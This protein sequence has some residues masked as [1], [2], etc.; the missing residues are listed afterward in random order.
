MLESSGRPTTG[1]I[2]R[3]TDPDRTAKGEPRASVT[4]TGLRTLWF[5]TGSLCN[6]AC[7]NC[8][9]ESSPTSDRLAYLSA[10]DVGH[11]LDEVKRARLPV[12]EVGFTGG[13]PFMNR[14]LPAMLA[15]ALGRGFRALVLTNAMK[16]M[17]HRRR[18]LLALHARHG[19]ALTLRVSIDH[20]QPAKHEKVRGAGTWVPM[21]EGLRWLAGHGFR[22]DAAGRKLWDETEADLRAGFAA[23]FR[24]EGIGIDADDPASLVL[25]PEMDLAR[26]APE[27]TTRC[28]DIVGKSP[29][30][31]MCASSRMVIRRKGA[32]SPVVVPCTLL[33]YDPK[34]E[35][36]PSVATAPSTVKLNHPFCA[37]FCVLGG[38]S[39]SAR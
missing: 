27:I 25:F 8:Y 9:I 33:P 10:A 6:I 13:E 5:N 32:A 3:F 12:E 38:A 19:A 1:V 16:P 20:Y 29:D 4:L 15:D 39:C 2:R 30:Q 23:L 35:L 26:D 36:G 18:E 21:L 28:W 11:Y 17:Q 37:Q 7:D 34:F 14:D 24:R 22:V 31:M